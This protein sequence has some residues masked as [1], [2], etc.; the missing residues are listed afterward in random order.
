M[1]FVALRSNIKEAISLIEKAVGENPNLPILKNIL[2]EAKDGVVLFTATNLEIAISHKVTGKIIEDGKIA[3]P[4]ALFSSLIAN[5]QSDRLNF[6]SKENNLEITTDNYRAVL[7]GLPSEDFPITPAV[8]EKERFIEIKGAILK[9]A[10]QQVVVAAQ[11]S[12][13]RPELNSVSFDFSFDSLV[14]AAT[15]GFRLTEKTIPANLFTSKNKEVFKMLVPLRTTLE[16]ARIIKDEEEVRLIWDENQI[17]IKTDG[18]ELISRLI[19]GSF[20]DYSGIIPHEFGAEVAVNREEFTAAIRLAGIFGQK[21]SEVKM[22]IHNNKKAVEITSADQAL[23]ENNNMLPAKI[24]GDIGEVFFNWRYLADA[25][26]GIKTEDV[27]LG[28]Q[29]DAGPA[30]IR[31]TSDSSY[32]YILKPILKA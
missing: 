21:N 20:P 15:D 8:E 28:L 24:K 2:I 30:L 31:S 16:I 7:N 26:K 27:F 10:I 19:E 32:F 14:L 9:E 17:L 3:P 5:I 6:E 4:L 23:G 29:E 22:N 1:K 13:L 11:F 12:D 18:T 25:M